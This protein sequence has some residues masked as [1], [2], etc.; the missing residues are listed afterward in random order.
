MKPLLG[1]PWCMLLVTLFIAWDGALVVAIAR[2]NDDAADA[3]ASRTTLRRPYLIAL[4]AYVVVVVLFKAAFAVLL[5]YVVC[6]LLAIT[7]PVVAPDTLYV[8]L[9]LDKIANP[10][11]VL[12][13]FDKKNALFHGAVHGLLLL[14]G[15]LAIGF[16]VT[17]DDLVDVS[18]AVTKMTRLFF[19]LPLVAVCAYVVYA[20]ALIIG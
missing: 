18:R 15:A 1:Y 16:Y 3:Q 13:A 2:M 8:R 19:T 14:F 17:D 6:A 11:L 10:T 4:L 9:V 7:R 20:V 5:L 12:A